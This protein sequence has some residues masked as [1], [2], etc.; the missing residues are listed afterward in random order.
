MKIKITWKRLRAPSV[1][2]TRFFTI[3]IFCGNSTGFIH[4]NSVIDL[5][6]L[7]Q[8]SCTINRQR[9]KRHTRVIMIIILRKVNY[10]K[11]LHYGNLSQ[12]SQ[13]LSMTLH[14]LKKRLVGIYL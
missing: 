11:V 3:S 1:L 8:T 9:I 14:R 6:F 7:K 2:P 10:R 5:Q 12:L 13:N 4:E